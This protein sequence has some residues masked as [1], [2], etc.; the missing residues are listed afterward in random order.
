MRLIEDLNRELDM[1]LSEVSLRK[2]FEMWWPSLERSLAAIASSDSENEKVLLR[3]M[4]DIAG[5][6]LEL[7][8]DLS[9]KFESIATQK[10]DTSESQ[11]ASG[12][13]QK[14]RDLQVYI[15]GVLEK[16][17]A[18]PY[19]PIV[20]DLA[21]TVTTVLKSMYHRAY[22]NRGDPPTGHQAEVAVGDMR[23]KF[24]YRQETDSYVSYRE[25]FIVHLNDQPSISW[26]G[27]THIDGRG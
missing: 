20:G 10:M 6:T 18:S 14:T 13:S 12:L 7:V 17:G 2:A 11:L 21:H 22:F 23:F 19:P 3:S 4:D 1:P 27:F 26:L 24:T 8:R 5:E 25:N 15:D 16:T 9:G